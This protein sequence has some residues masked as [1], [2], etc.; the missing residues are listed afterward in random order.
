[1]I[2]WIQRC[3]G[4]QAAKRTCSF[5]AFVMFLYNEFQ[6]SGTY[7]IINVS[8]NL[9]LFGNNG[10]TSN[11]VKSLQYE[12][13]GLGQYYNI[14]IEKF[15]T[16]IWFSDLH[17]SPFRPGWQQNCGILFI[18]PR[19]SNGSLI[20]GNGQNMRLLLFLG[21]FIWKHIWIIGLKASGNY[22]DQFLGW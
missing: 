11:V 16:Y 21:L 15:K 6:G 5:L 14:N 20:G 7:Y 1:M 2:L 12:F 22:S 10:R 17:N 4:T 3:L 8:V 19:Y 9:K 18:Y 13:L